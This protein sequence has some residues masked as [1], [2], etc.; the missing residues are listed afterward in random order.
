MYDVEHR[1]F[2]HYNSWKVDGAREPCLDDAKKMA[3]ALM[4]A[5]NK[6]MQRMGCSEVRKA[7]VLDKETPQQGQSRD[8]LLFMCHFMKV[9]SKANVKGY[10]LTPLPDE[11][12][13]EKL[14]K[15]RATIT[16]KMLT[17]SGVSEK[18]WKEEDMH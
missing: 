6:F 7:E 12:L 3:E 5:I 2:L 15:K 17:A 14:F 16:Y 18:S 4:P 1:Y 13:R 11:E 8:C 10:D 9:Y